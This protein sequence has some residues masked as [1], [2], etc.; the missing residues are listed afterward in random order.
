MFDVDGSQAASSGVDFLNGSK[1]VRQ[2]KEVNFGNA[3]VRILPP[4]GYL[5]KGLEHAALLEVFPYVHA[6]SAAA[7][8]GAR[9][10]NA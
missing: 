4:Q 5:P 8:C 10:T 7:K 3:E 9:P 6:A 1:F 2:F